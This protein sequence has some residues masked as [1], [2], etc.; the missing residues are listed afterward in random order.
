M[1]L[2]ERFVFFADILGFSELVRARGQEEVFKTI[3]AC[4]DESRGWVDGQN[5]ARLYFSDTLVIYSR[6]PGFEQT[7]W[8]DFLAIASRM[9]VALAARKIPTRSTLAFG[10]FMV[11]RDE[12]GEHDIFFG[13]ALVEAAKAEK[14]TPFI[15]TVLC[16]SFV[17]R[18]SA[19][20][21]AH[22][23][24]T[25]FLWQME[26]GRY[27][28]NPLRHLQHWPDPEWIDSYALEFPTRLRSSPED[29]YLLQQE[30]LA[31]D[32]L[33]TQA[34]ARHPEKVL[35]KYRRTLEFFQRVLRSEAIEWA[36]EAASGLKP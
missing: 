21:L 28:V 4:L 8:D 6:E 32:F 24:E 23:Q 26:D 18:H 30:V 5:F 16:P 34:R 19:A 3:Q 22:L 17:Q 20:Y 1:T 31:L 35:E 25:R 10:P 7:V 9:F 27:Y 36:R 33:H 15:G 29:T 2:E 12:R 13:T 14:D 11:Q